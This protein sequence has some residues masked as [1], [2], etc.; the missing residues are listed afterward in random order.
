MAQLQAELDRYRVV[1]AE[2]SAENLQLKKGA[3]ALGRHRYSADQKRCILEAVDL[4]QARAACGL[5][6][7][8]ADLGLSRATYYRWLQRA[9]AGRLVDRLVVPHRQRGRPRPTRSPR[10]VVSL[11]STRPWA[12]SA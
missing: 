5:R 3:L 4:A 10:S 6:D 7:I 2:L 1:V 8:L 11:A 12:T 9:A